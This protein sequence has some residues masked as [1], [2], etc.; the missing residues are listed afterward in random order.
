MSLKELTKDVHRD[1]ERQAFVKVLM[2]G[3]I[4]P[5]LY[6]TFM[7]NQHHQYDILEVNCMAHGLLNGLMDIRRAPSIWA[8]YEELWEDKDNTPELLPVTKEYGEYIMS[9]KEDKER[10]FAHIYTR[11][12][13]DLSGGQMIR[14]KIPGSGKL[15][16]FEDGAKLKELIRERL[17]DSMADEARVCF[18]FA[19]KTFQEIMDVDIS[20]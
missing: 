13:G 7:F 4:D 19:T 8:D 6:A 3:E 20:K 15:Y 5:K 10:L 16:D 1:A 14:R 9:I 11:H 12:M 18:E 17:D 2:S